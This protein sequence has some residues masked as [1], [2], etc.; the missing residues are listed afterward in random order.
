MAKEILGH[1]SDNIKAFWYGANGCEWI[2]WKG[3]H[4]VFVFPCEEYPEKPDMIVEHIERIESVEE[5]TK[6]IMTGK[7]FKPSY[8]PIIPYWQEG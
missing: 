7:V 3:S 8:K 1:W 4:H 5:F 2:A 6:A